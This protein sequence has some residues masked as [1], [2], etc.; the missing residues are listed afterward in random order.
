MEFVSHF[1]LN[2]FSPGTLVLATNVYLIL[3][4]LKELWENLSLCSRSRVVLL[5]CNIPLLGVCH[6]LKLTVTEM[7]IPSSIDV[8]SVGEV[9]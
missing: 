6:T 3:T 1:S 5:A 4:L 7:R 9:I 8:H 2:P